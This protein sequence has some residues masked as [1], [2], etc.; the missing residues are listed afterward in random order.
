VSDRIPTLDGWRGVAVIIVLLHH[1]ELYFDNRLLT[2]PWAWI[3]Q[4][5][6]TMFF[7]VSGYLIT[8]NLLGNGDLK[9][10]YVRRFFRLMPAAWVYL[11]TV[12]F[13]AVFMPHKVTVGRD[14][15]GC[16]FFF[17]NYIGLNVPT[18]F[19]GHFWS[20][21]IE[22]QFYFVWPTL[23]VLLGRRKSAAVAVLGIATIVAYRALHPACMAQGFDYF[24]GTEYRLDAIMVGCLLAFVMSDVR[25]RG[26]IT[27]H[28]ALL[29]WAC[30]PV[31]AFDFWRYQ[32]VMPLHEN[33]ALALML[34]STVTNSRLIASRVLELPHLKTT[35]MLCYGIY[36]WQGLLLRQVF[37]PFG[38]I[39]MPV[40]VLGSW[41]LIEQPCQRLGLR[42]LKRSVQNVSKVEPGA[43]SRE[44]TLGLIG[45]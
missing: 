3:G 43:G 9:R 25:A 6:V 45:H 35:G 42:L 11:A 10:F 26:W 23:L 15:L 34:A 13:L 30:V 19:T 27:E 20:L 17:R 38:F 36:L 8:T 2:Y 16:L 39:L 12:C 24:F 14:I 7:V 1:Y 44:R 29:F 33:V 21:S 41:A 32:S 28:S 4:H 22:E 31:V 40:T 18:N 37:D 5:G